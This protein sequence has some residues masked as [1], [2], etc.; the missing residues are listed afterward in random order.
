ME[1]DPTRMCERFVNLPDVSVLGFD[2]D[3]R[4]PLVI[5]FES[6]RVDE[7]C[8]ECGV[9]AS[10]KDRPF[11]TLV[12][13]PVNG[14]ATTVVWHK[15]W[16]HCVEL[17]CSTGSWTEQDSRIAF[18]RHSTTDR[19]GRWLTKQIGKNGRSVKDGDR[20]RVAHRL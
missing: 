20:L 13:L 12:D 18:A 1:T 17:D 14:R 19:A 4:D 15:H 3:C 11:V 10:V 16:F 6:K 5:Q 7:G 2:G 9:V 8:P